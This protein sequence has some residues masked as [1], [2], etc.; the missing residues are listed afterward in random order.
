MPLNILS[1]KLAEVTDPVQISVDSTIPVRER[2]WQIE[3]TS[4]RTVSMAQLM[5]KQE[6]IRNQIAI[7]QTQ[8][9]AITAQIA[10]LED[11]IGQEEGKQIQEAGMAQFRIPTP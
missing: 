2:S 1:A 6:T 9:D 4:T 5:A 11:L 10:S 7:L 8:D 3:E